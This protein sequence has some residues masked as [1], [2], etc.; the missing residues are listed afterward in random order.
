[1]IDLHSHILPGMD[2]GAIHWDQSLQMARMAV[3][4]GIKAIVCTP[5]CIPGLFDNTRT[6]VLE[7]VDRFRTK[8]GEANIPLEVYPG[9]ELR[10]E[11]DLGDRIESGEILTMNDTGRYAL[12]ELPPEMLPPHLDNYFW[13]LQS[14]GI[15]PIIAH[16]ERHPV[17]MRKAEPLW[18]WVD[19]GVLTQ[20]TAASLTGRFGSAVRKFSVHLVK[21]RVAHVLATDAHGPKARTPKLTHAYME[22]RAL[23]GEERAV[24]MI[25]GIPRL[26]LDGEPVSISRPI[27]LED[28]AGEAS[29]LKRL[30]SFFR[31]SY[32]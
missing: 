22:V 29:G 23:L 30:F 27:P 19:M 17:L 28:R 7:A 8:L 14:R 26:I 24:E 2:D 6:H 13:D 4:D 32:A 25:Q 21:H 11:L 16:P 5:H 20:I 15:T 18:R 31:R 3:E 12:I 1:M 9:S 10:L